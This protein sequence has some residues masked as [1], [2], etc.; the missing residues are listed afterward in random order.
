MVGRTSSRQAGFTLIELIVVM[1][2]MGVISFMLIGTWFALQGS[3]THSANLLDD[4]STARDAIST[5]SAQIRDAQ[6]Q[7]I[8]TPAASPFTAAGPDEIDFYSSWDRPGTASDGTGTAT[9]LLTRVYLN[10]TTDTLYWQQDTN[11]D[12]VWDA[13]D[14]QLVLAQ[15]VVNAA[16]PVFTY[17]C[18]SNGS[19]TS[20]STV[21][22]ANL[23]TIVSVTV[24]LQVAPN[25]TQTQNP[26]DLQVTVVPRNAPDA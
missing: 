23:G 26:A 15:D 7:T 2:I 24:H 9:L 16:T 20:A 3:F 6:P 19:Y 10:T 1:V 8:T 14:T 21:A 4:D 17:E 18:L 12:R 5:I 11:D 13:G 22:T 25:T